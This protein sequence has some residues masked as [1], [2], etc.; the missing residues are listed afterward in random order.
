VTAVG[1][2]ILNVMHA[3]AGTD[4]TQARDYHLE[5][6]ADVVHPLP[7]SRGQEAAPA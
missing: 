7:V 5:S 4:E 2:L 3:P 1:S 6:D